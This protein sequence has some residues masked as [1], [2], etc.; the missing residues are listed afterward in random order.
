LIMSPFIGFFSTVIVV[1]LYH[2]ENSDA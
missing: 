2:G 1:M